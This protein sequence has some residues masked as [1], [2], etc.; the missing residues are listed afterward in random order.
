VLEVAA[1]YFG[2][3]P[4]LSSICLFWSV[5]ND[6]V[7]SSQKWHVDGEDTR[8]LK[9]FVN[10]WDLAD[11]NG[12]LTFYPASTTNTI[13]DKA[14]RSTR[15]NAAEA[16]F[17]DDFIDA[18]TSRQPPIKV[19]GEAGAGVFIDT[20]RCIHFGSRRNSKERLML[21][22][23]YAPYN[24]ARESTVALGSTDWIPHDPADPLQRLALQHS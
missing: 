21:M 9:L 3:A 17:D 24:L 15:L 18:G 19:V 11:E 6:S 16:N 10:S 2:S 14:A 4:I 20:S 12:P 5:I 23:Q 7:V 22:V 1:G 13:L 8:Q